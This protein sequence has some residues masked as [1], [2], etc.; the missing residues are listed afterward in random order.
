MLCSNEKG[1][2]KKMTRECNKVYFEN[3]FHRIGQDNHILLKT[4]YHK[5]IPEFDE[6]QVRRKPSRLK[7]LLRTFIN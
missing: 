2:D 3:G 5:L 4:D 1:K 7:R 6:K